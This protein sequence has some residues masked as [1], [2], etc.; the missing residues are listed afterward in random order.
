MAKRVKFGDVIEIV[1]SKGYAY[2][3]YTHKDSMMGALLRIF[4]GIYEKKPSNIEQVLNNEIQFSTFFP[5]QAAVN[6]K[7]VEIIANCEIRDDLIAFPIMRVMGLTDPSTKKAISWGLRDGDSTFKRVRTLTEEEKKL[8]IE[9]TCNDTMLISRIESE[10]T[11]E[12]DP[13]T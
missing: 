9:E 3:Q 2:A 13:N 6:R 10:W 1:T 11:P 8:P 5:L 12:Q 4:K 7:I